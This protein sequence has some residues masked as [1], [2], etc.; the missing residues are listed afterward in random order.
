MQTLIIFKNNLSEFVS[1]LTGQ[2]AQL[3][4]KGQYPEIHARYNTQPACVH[5]LCLPLY[6]SLV[7]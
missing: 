7:S 2:A 4:I 5:V 1:Y 3:A 6:T